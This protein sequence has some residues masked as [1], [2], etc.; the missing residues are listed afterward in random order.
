[1]K[2][3]YKFRYETAQGRGNLEK[4]ELIEILNRFGP[5]NLSV[6]EYTPDAECPWIGSLKYLG[7]GDE[8]MEE[9]AK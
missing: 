9:N 4:E 7:H 3:A 8:W 5:K 2:Y 1:M 6:Y